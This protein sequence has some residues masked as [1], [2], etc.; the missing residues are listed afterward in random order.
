[1]STH[2]NFGYYIFTDLM[3]SYGVDKVE[4]FI[5]K[6]CG[7]SIYIGDTN[8]QSNAWTD[9]HINLRCYTTVN[10]SSTLMESMSACPAKLLNLN[11]EQIEYLCKEKGYVPYTIEAGTYPGQDEDC[12]TV[13]IDTVLVVR[14]DLPEDV[15]YFI[16]KTIYENQEFLA[17]THSTYEDFLPDKMIDG[18]NAEDLHPG[19]VKFYR[20]VGL[21]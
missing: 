7:G 12:S 16:T 10:P 2:G 19:A 8:T 4:N 21:R 1:M 5:E 17:A 15:I 18:L 3:N 13:Y 6:E 14:N 11:P 20:E 9:G